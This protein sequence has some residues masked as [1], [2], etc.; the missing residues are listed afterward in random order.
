MKEN[1]KKLVKPLV[2]VTSM[3]GPNI[4]ANASET[5]NILRN[6]SSDN[7]N[8]SISEPIRPSIDF[9]NLPP[10]PKPNALTEALE[11]HLM[12]GIGDEAEQDIQIEL[13]N[14]VDALTQSFHSANDRPQSEIIKDI[15]SI[16]YADYHSLLEGFSIEGSINAETEYTD[17]IN[18]IFD[19]DT[20]SSLLFSLQEN[21]LHEILEEIYYGGSDSFYAPLAEKLSHAENFDGVRENVFG[22]VEELKLSATAC[23]LNT[24]AKTSAEERK[25]SFYDVLTTEDTSLTVMFGECADLYL[26]KL[27]EMDRV[28]FLED[29]KKN[30][31]GALLKKLQEEQKKLKFDGPKKEARSYSYRYG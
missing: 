11:R 19:S 31:S 22:T 5:L 20:A 23:F 18:G 16:I 2:V 27:P 28:L 24:W 10:F 6:A 1:L 17:G 29:I 14:L 15:Q 25:N 13:G 4:P 21:D 30:M 26:N 12:E 9:N 3:F 8:Q 7:D